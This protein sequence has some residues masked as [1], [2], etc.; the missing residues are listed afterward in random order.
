VDK[1][2]GAGAGERGRIGDNLDLG[3]QNPE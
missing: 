1:L 2:F 3:A